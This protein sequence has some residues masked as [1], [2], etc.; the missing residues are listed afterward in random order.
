MGTSIRIATVFG[1]AGFIG[2]H[3]IRRLAKTGCVIRVPA[4]HP[5]EAAFL[6]T[7]GAVGQIV[8]MAVDIADDAS[9]ARA[10]EGA[11]VVINLMGILAEGGRRQRFDLVHTEAAGR[12]ARL[13][14]GADVSRLVHVSALGVDANSR[15][16]YSR[17]KAAGE[18]AV[19]A[20]F[21]EATILR[22]SVVF[23]PEDNFFNRF[24][25]MAKTLPFV[26]LIGG[27]AT[28][29]QPVYVGDV[30][31]AIVNAATR[32][33]AEGKTYELG[34]PRAYSFRELI[35]LTLDLTGRKTRLISIPWGL[36]SLQA[37][38]LEMVPGKPLTRDQVILLKSDNVLSG[39]L[40]GL[41]D[42]GV[43]PTAAEVILPTYLD[44]FQV[45]GR[46]GT[47]RQGPSLPQ[48]TKV[49]AHGTHY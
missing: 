47:H 8:P 16:A 20:V 14:K 35:Q 21:P 1:G 19:R 17:S 24:A 41:A 36:A 23:G 3:V 34:G 30:A 12:I 15:S 37:A 4:R 48:L 28:R 38:F 33:G 10:I 27:G 9:V 22:P 45:G 44:R 42:L 43:A 46:Y 6:K 40:P 49:D 7:N 29:F 5:G 13:A 18:Q 26:P 39:K 31:D 11:D 2:R 25:G 32:A